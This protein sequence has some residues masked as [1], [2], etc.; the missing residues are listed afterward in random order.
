MP[1]EPTYTTCTHA[2]PDG[3]RYQASVVERENGQEVHRTIWHVSEQQAE[4]AAY[5]WLNDERQRQASEAW[6]QAKGGT[7]YVRLTPREP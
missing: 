3:R 2:A 5:D 1:T 6:R 7:L 4:G